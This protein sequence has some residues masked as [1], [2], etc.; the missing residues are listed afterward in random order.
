MA[1]DL[2]KRTTAS[3]K[4]TRPQIEILCEKT[5]S[6][7][8]VLVE[9]PEIYPGQADLLFPQIAHLALDLSKIMSAQPQG[10]AQELKSLSE[11]FTAYHIFIK[12]GIFPRSSQL[13][14]V[15]LKTLAEWKE[16]FRSEWE[17]KYE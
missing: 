8:D 4:R 9:T 6:L 10:P 13:E 17:E 1:I 2:K 16:K 5:Q 11:K 7:I 15:H 14:K 3:E 12:S